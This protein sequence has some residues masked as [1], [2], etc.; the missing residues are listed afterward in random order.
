MSHT[1]L[2]VLAHPDDETFG[3]GGTLALY[4][5]QRGVDVFLVCGTR[6]EV[7]EMDPKFMEGYQSVAERREAELRCAAENLGLKGV[8]FLD[9]RDSGMPGSPDN[10]HPKALV[11]QPMQQVAADIAHYIRLL[12]PQ[13]VITFDPIGGYRHPDHIAIHQATVRAFFAAPDPT[14]F[15]GDLPPHS[16]DR[17]YFHTIPNTFL[18]LAVRLMPLFGRDPRRFG[19]NQDIDLVSIAQVQFPTH[20]VIGYREVA[21]Q[22]A[23]AAA[24]HESQGGKQMSSGLLPRLQRWFQ[25]KETFMQAYPEPAADARQT[26]LFAGL[27]VTFSNPA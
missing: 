27:P 23:Q 19:Q 24:C 15:P 11:A 26:D 3:T 10:N 13:V 18:R 25:A 17:L 20:A 5:R 12:R 22:R 16:P 2:A 6:G 9:Y 1:L 4:A 8:D 21:E 14:A 7:G